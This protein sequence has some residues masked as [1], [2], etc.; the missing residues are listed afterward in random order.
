[1]S[2]VSEFFTWIMHNSWK[3]WTRDQNIDSLKEIS[4]LGK[5]PRNIQG[6]IHKIRI[7][8]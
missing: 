6:D 7:Y 8:E 1:M 4:F 5:F 3:G 2:Y